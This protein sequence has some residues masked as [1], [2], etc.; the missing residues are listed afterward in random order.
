[1]FTNA[2]KQL[3]VSVS[4]RMEY[5]LSLGQKRVR[6]ENEVQ[7]DRFYITQAALSREMLKKSLLE[8]LV[9]SFEEFIETFEDLKLPRQLDMV[10]YAVMKTE[11]DLFVELQ[12]FD[13]AIRVFKTL[14]D[15]VNFW[16]HMDDLKYPVYE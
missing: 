10:F 14:K 5:L 13:Y 11:G 8:N 9:G 4:K 2:L 16:G 6:G 7:T 15:F 12:E 1:M 3:F